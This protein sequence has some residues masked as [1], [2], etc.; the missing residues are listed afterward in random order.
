MKCVRI[1]H[2]IIIS[3]K[4]K[5]FGQWSGLTIGEMEQEILL[6]TDDAP[7][8]QLMINIIIR[9]QKIMEIS[10]VQRKWF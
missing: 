8:I 5:M 4:P 7:Q 1:V 6:S 10:H 2:S 3:R 9:F